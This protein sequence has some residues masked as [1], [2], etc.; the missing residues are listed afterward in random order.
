M[1][2]RRQL[3]AS[4]SVAALPFTIGVSATAPDFVYVVE[5]ERAAP[6]TGLFNFVAAGWGAWSAAQAMPGAT[7]LAFALPRAE[8][9]D[10]R[11]RPLLSGS[12]V[13]LGSPGAVSPTAFR[14]SLDGGAA[15]DLALVAIAPV[16][17]C[18]E[19]GETLDLARR[20]HRKMVAMVPAAS[21]V[22]ER[23]R[24]SAPN[25]LT[26]ACHVGRIDPDDS[27]WLAQCHAMA[28]CGRLFWQFADGGDL[29]GGGFTDVL[30][31]SKECLPASIE[32]R[33]S[34]SMRASVIG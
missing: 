4:A 2:S 16:E 24:T 19:I 13:E 8:L 14:A 28:D 23:L 18:P 32:P 30:A 17:D 7:H 11:A 9:Q 33:G 26:I 1:F 12:L 34:T 25:D 21:G 22:A 6:P 5:R 10:Y 20:S 31:P 3:L 27:E 29:V 15:A